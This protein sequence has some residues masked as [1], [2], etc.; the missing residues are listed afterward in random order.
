MSTENH[1]RNPFEMALQ[2]LS[3][4]ISEAGDIA[5][6]PR[7]HVAQAPPVIRRIEV[8]DLWDALR[9]GAGDLGAIRDDVLFIGLI[10]PVAGLVLARLT[11]SYNLLPLVLPLVA[12]FALIGPV[13]A[14]G[15][16]EISR[17]REQGM[18][19]TWATAFGVVRSPALG[20]ILWLGSMLLGLFVLWLAAAYGIYLATLGPAPPISVAAF[21]HD[22]FLTGAGWAM[23]VAGVGVGFLFAAL[24]L[25]ISVVSFPLLL[26][27][28]VG[29]TRAIATSVRAVA[30]N[31]GPMALWGA[32]VVA[33][34]VLGS[35]PALLGLIFVMPVL[36]HATWHLYRKVIAEA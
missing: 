20:S 36:G 8:R 18:H 9:K 25:A 14:I 15:L 22:V 11:F 23:I 26:D 17:R 32:I 24:A 7:V 1:I 13:A 3:S 30:A 34:L 28:N 21:M 35:A 31:P 2:Q 6:K 10:Y 12:G 16:Y 29:M 33:G 27:R 4:V 19:V 5:V